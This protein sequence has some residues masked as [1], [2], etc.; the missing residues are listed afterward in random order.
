VK[1]SQF[2]HIYFLG[3]GGIGMSALARYFNVSNKKVSGYD[4]TPS[5][6]TEQ[7][8]EEG[9]S[10]HFQ[11]LGDNIHEEIPNKEKTLVVYTPAIPV[12]MQEKRYLESQ[13]YILLKRA[14]VLGLI[15]ES[16]KSLAVAGT[17]GKTTTSA[18]LAHVLMQSE[19]KCNAFLGG[20]STNY[21]SNLI[22]ENES[23]IAVVEADEFDKSFLK[24][25]PFA[26]ILTSTDADH[27]DIYENADSLKNAFQTYAD[28]LPSEGCLVLQHE[29]ALH[30]KAK[31]ISY[32]VNTEEVNVAF[33]GNNLRVEHG[34]FL[35]DVV[36]PKGDWEA[37]RMGVP[38]IHNAENALGVIALCDF[39]GF[40]EPMIR[41]GLSSFQGVKRRFEYHIRNKDLVFIDDYAHHPTAI[42]SLIASVR[43]LHPNLSITAVFQ[44][45]LF[46]RTADFMD[47]FATSLDL[48]DQVYLLPIY[49]AREQPIPG[50]TSLAIAEKM[51]NKNTEVL[52][53]K[54]V[55]ERLKNIQSGVVLTIGAGNIDQ[56]VQPIKQLLA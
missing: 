49:P 31:I 1:L 22:I 36:T 13:G 18:M 8:V 26:S 33:R 30:S 5:R 48:A 32:G 14:A 11:D 20:I 24:L 19:E 43:L 34:F 40:D 17:H 47:D 2:E 4:R 53:N 51:K 15:T 35:M 56:I 39:L 50:V 16:F 7:L 3:I 38:G 29:I 54:E 55:L 23:N 44:P 27:L 21:N 41:E 25:S 10:I 28:L 46:S 6:L 9:I 45:H 12:D 37:V 42:K 52:H